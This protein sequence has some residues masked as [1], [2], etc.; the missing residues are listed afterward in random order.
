MLV[1]PEPDNGMACDSVS[2]YEPFGVGCLESDGDEGCV[3]GSVRN[4]GP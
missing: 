1:T 2:M 4:S 3:G